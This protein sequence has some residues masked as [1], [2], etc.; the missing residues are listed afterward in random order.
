LLRLPGWNIIYHS[1]FL[2]I[3]C[4]EKGYNNMGDTFA[5]FCGLEKSWI[6]DVGGWV[7]ARK[8]ESCLEGWLKCWLKVEGILLASNDWRRLELNLKTSQEAVSTIL[9]AFS[10]L[11]IKTP[12]SSPEKPFALPKDD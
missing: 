8:F 2:R 1:S 3:F 7:T 9:P 5:F 11:L 6:S 10:L 4:S 12:R